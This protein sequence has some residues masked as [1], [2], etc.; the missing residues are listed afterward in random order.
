MSHFPK[1]TFTSTGQ[2]ASPEYNF[3]KL[4]HLFTSVFRHKSFADLSGVLYEGKDPFMG[5]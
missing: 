2:S 5:D 1:R 3:S 4:L